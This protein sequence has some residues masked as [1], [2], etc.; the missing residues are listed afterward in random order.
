MKRILP[1]LVGTILSGHAY[2]LDTCTASNEDTQVRMCSYNMTQRYAVNGVLGFPVNIR[3]APEETIKRAD[4]AYTGADKDGKPTATWK[5]PDK[6]DKDDKRFMNNLPI[7]P[8]FEGRSSLVVITTT[9]DGAERTYVFELNARKPC[10]EDCQQDTTTTASLLFVY[11]DDA[12]AK[13][14][15]EAEQKKKDAVASWRAQQAKSSEATAVARLKTDVFYGNQNPQ[16]RAKG[17]LAYKYLSPSQITDN[18]QLTEMEWPGNVEIPT[19]TFLNKKTGEE[20]IPAISQQGRMMIVNG[21]SEW[22]RLR[23]GAKAVIDIQNLKW[24]LERPDPETGTT[25]SDVVRQ[26]TYRDHQ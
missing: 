15:A 12:K 11:P 13:A 25:S 10:A 4:F 19:I 18:G 3:F 2:A 22:F 6:K 1:L 23:L 17:N 21:T 14:A 5:G 8:F 7:W 24:S 9:A 16:Y 20:R 26:I